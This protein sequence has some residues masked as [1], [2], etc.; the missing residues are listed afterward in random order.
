VSEVTLDTLE[1]ATVWRDR[2]LRDDRGI[3]SDEDV[4]T[5]A[6]LSSLWVALTRERFD[7]RRLECEADRRALLG[8][9]SG[10]RLPVHQP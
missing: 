4:W 1:V 7:P 10:Q 5:M 9:V 3:F 8:H 6:N 2:S